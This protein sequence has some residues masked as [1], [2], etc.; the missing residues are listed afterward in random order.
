MGD[1]NGTGQM[2][3]EKNT[4]S[5]MYA[6]PKEAVK[7]QS[8]DVFGVRQE[9]SQRSVSQRY[10]S[11]KAYKAYLKIVNSEYAGEKWT[12][13]VSGKQKEK[14]GI[15]P[16]YRITAGEG[17]SA[18]LG[19]KGLKDRGEEY[20][21]RKTLSEKAAAE[22]DGISSGEE[23]AEDLQQ[24]IKKLSGADPAGFRAESDDRFVEGFA[25]NIKLLQQAK[26]LR[27]HLGGPEG[28]DDDAAQDGQLASNLEQMES[29][30]QEYE[31]RIRI[32]SSAYY[33]SLGEGEFTENT[34]KYMR[35]KLQGQ[36]SPDPFI[37]AYLGQYDRTHQEGAAAV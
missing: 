3:R 36:D 26:R 25:E 24:L 16:G 22:L 37:K 18:S 34:V 19:V 8:Q 2:F 31:D 28:A 14:N 35:E 20:M 23:G 33:P 1:P 5:M 4:N 13:K 6:A 21:L 11:D 12:E 17:F 27:D 15:D 10:Y 29:V 9:V 30:R 7:N 32:I